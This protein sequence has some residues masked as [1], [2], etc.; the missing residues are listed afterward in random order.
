[1]KPNLPAT[2]V[3]LVTAALP[4]IALGEGPKFKAVLEGSQEVPPV[5]TATIGT[6]EAKFNDDLTDADFELKVLNGTKVLQAH[7]HCAPAGVNGPVFASWLPTRVFRYEVR[8]WEEGALADREYA[9]GGPTFLSDTQAVAASILA[10][11]RSVPA[12]TWGRDQSRVGGMWNSNSVISWLLTRAGYPMETLRPPH[13][14]R[15][16]GWDAGVAIAS[17]GT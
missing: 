1:M 15:A 17:R 6:F 4:A 11:V 10:S 7:L 16:P 2:C 13:G 3:L 12:L 9:V 5:I 8:C 14:T